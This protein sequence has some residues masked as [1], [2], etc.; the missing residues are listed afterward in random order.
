MGLRGS[1][2]LQLSLNVEASWYPELSLLFLEWQIVKPVSFFFASGL[3]TSCGGFGAGLRFLWGGFGRS[4]GGSSFGG[5]TPGGVTERESSLWVGEIERFSL[6]NEPELYK[7]TKKYFVAILFTY[8]YTN[9]LSSSK[10]QIKN[11]PASLIMNL[12]SFFLLS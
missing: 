3:F 5:G 6:D 9:R 1:E 8:S 4:A 2:V 12:L 10:N 11:T 7:N